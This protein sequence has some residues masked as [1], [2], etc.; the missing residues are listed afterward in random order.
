MSSGE[1]SGECVDATLMSETIRY[2]NLAEW[3]RG[4]H[5]A[6]CVVWTDAPVFMCE[7]GAW[8]REGT[9]SPALSLLSGTLR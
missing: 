1:G 8:D 9:D 3:H 4:S 7:L 2:I 6:S 5:R